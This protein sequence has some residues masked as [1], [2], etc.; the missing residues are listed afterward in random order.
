MSLLQTP[1]KLF[2]VDIKYVEVKYK[3]GLTGNHVIEGPEDEKKF[4]TEEIKE[5]HTQWV[6]PNWKEHTDVIRQAMVWDDML[7]ERK[8]DYR[9]YRGLCLENF[10][11]AWDIVDAEGKP[12]PCNKTTIATLDLDIAHALQEA[13][14]DRSIP[15]ET[16][17]KN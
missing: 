9:T 1:N 4:A 14:V 8:L 13:F 12:V 5:L 15:T 6:M 3:N 7:G 17:L 16:E 2:P 11:R 10:M